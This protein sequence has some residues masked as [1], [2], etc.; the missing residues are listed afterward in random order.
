MLTLGSSIVL[1]LLLGLYGLTLSSLYLGLFFFFGHTC[2]LALLS[3]CTQTVSSSLWN[4]E[5]NLTDASFFSWV[6]IDGLSCPNALL[7]SATLFRDAFNH[8]QKVFIPSIALYE[9]HNVGFEFT[10]SLANRYH[11]SYR[12]R[13]VLTSHSTYPNNFFFFETHF[14]S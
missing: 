9:Q 2:Y 12:P 5:C 14:L 10:T 13:E 1:P 7:A 11:W 8:H 6:F 4:P 3:M